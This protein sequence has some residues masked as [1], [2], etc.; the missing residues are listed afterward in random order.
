[1]ARAPNLI[2][3]QADNHT[4]RVAGCYG[5]D[6]VRTPSLD[7][8]AARGV[9]FDNAYSV[10]ALCCPSRAGLATGRYPHQTGYWDNVLA[11]DGRV[12]SWMRR[13]REAG[14]SV[15]AIGKLHYRSADDDNGLTEEINP[16]HIVGGRGQ[17]SALL[18]WCGREPP[19]SAQRDVYLNETGVGT[20]EYQ[21]YD[22]D[23]T[24]R[25]VRWLGQ[26]VERSEP[27]TLVVSYT[28]PHPPFRVPQPLLDLYPVDRMP[29]PRQFA[30]G[31]R[32]MHPAVEA[33]RRSKNYRDM[34]DERDLRRIAAGYFSL[35]TFVDEQVGALMHATESAGLLDCTRVIYTSD[36]GELYGNHGLFGKSCLY[37]EAVGVPLLIAGPGV[38]EGRAVR[39]LVSHVDLFP[40]I[41]ESAQ[42][43]LARDENP[44]PGVSLWPAIEGRETART[45]FAEYHGTGSKAGSFML[46][47]GGSKLI[48][49]VGQQPQLFDLE[50]DPY[51]LH[52]LG[53][54]PGWAGERARLERELRAICDPE[55]VDARAKADQERRAEEFGG[56]EAILR[57]GVFRRSPPPGIAPDYTHPAT[58]QGRTA[59]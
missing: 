31:E 52:D 8:I 7:R 39:Q 37:E 13:L 43:A 32:P 48:Y 17:V 4:R 1:M 35:V 42:V 59:V 51:E 2:V 34:W 6:V 21:D 23:I 33:L 47:D 12:P 11:Y 56:T 28:S 30:D 40:T 10:S 5:H 24:A 20:S 49:H 9:R 50:R 55:A 58:T 29:V 3:I 44:L 19:M 26:R 45:A 25:A 53:S 41:L 16:M 27:W 54:E 15:T 18:R 36:H 38:P 22:R 46:R 57:A 14:Q